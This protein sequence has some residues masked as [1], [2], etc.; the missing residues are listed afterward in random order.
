MK[1]L[2]DSESTLALHAQIFPNWEVNQVCLSGYTA[3]SG[4]VKIHFHHFPIGPRAVVSVNGVGTRIMGDV[5][6]TVK[7]TLLNIKGKI[8]KEFPGMV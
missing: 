8:A 5:C 6:E 2:F 3:V 7:E 1:R 4:C